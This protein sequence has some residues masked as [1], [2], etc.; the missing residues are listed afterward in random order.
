[1]TDIEKGLL[2][3]FEAKMRQLLDVC[4]AQDDKIRELTQSNKEAKQTI[5]ILQGKYKDL[6]TAH[7]VSLDE[8]DVKSARKRIGKLVQEIEKCIA[9]LNG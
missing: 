9:L 8:G 3:I 1:M 2:A 5:E 6:L 7:V 4:K